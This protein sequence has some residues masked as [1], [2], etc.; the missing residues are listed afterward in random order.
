MDKDK[1][2]D[3]V[4]IGG[5]PAGLTAGVYAGRARMAT[6]LVE[7]GISGGQ[8]A[9]TEMVENYP[10]FP[11]GIAGAEL[12]NRMEEQATHFGVEI[13]NDEVEGLEVQ[14]PVKV[15][16][17]AGGGEVRTRCLILATGADHRRLGVPGEEEYSGRGVSYCATCDGAFF[18]DQDLIVVGGGDSAVEEG[19]F[20]T[21]FARSVTI[22][23]RRDELR[24]Q[25]I[26]QE[27]AKREP[28]VRFVWNTVVEAIH[29]D[30]QKVTGV[31]TRDVRTGQRGELPA[32]GVFIYVGMNPGTA[33]LPAGVALDGEKYVVVDGNLQTSVPGVFAAGD[34]RQKQV[35][36]VA[37]AVGDGT[38]AA[39]MAEKY[40]AALEG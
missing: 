30:G 21:R 9:L 13:L 15:V 35:R 39:M 17:T 28:K 34:C 26:L 7:K 31:A 24:A 20:L 11:R 25:A 3:V 12:A 37:N 33:F 40:V 36:Q 22:V 1:I 5:G 18:R 23:H 6:L 14:E 38:V 19:L 8:M 4:I 32:A 27:R 16:R 2:Y 29:G 10:G